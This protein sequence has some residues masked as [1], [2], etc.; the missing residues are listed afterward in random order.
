M[1]IWFL[2]QGKEVSIN[3]DNFFEGIREWE[4]AGTGELEQASGFLK[5]GHFHK[6]GWT[7]QLKSRSW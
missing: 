6:M 2:L 1:W 3:A 4:E 7:R 5:N